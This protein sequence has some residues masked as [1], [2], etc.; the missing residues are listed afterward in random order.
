MKGSVRFLVLCT[1]V[2]VA[3]CQWVNQTQLGTLPLQRTDASFVY[4]A[5]QNNNSLCRNSPTIVK[6]LRWFDDLNNQRWAQKFLEGVEGQKFLVSKVEAKSDSWISCTPGESE[7]RGQTKIHLNRPFFVSVR[8]ADVEFLRQTMYLSGFPRAFWSWSVEDIQNTC[9]NNSADR[10]SRSRR[11][12]R[13]PKRLSVVLYKE[14]N[15]KRL[16]L[17]T[18]TRQLLTKLDERLLGGCPNCNGQWLV[19]SSNKSWP[20]SGA[21]KHTPLEIKWLKLGIKS[22]CC[23]AIC[24]GTC[25]LYQNILLALEPLLPWSDLL[26]NYHLPHLLPSP[27]LTPCCNTSCL[28]FANKDC[29]NKLRTFHKRL[30]TQP[31]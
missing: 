28:K 26:P 13:Q 24:R 8:P 1:I 9:W 4:S 17:K 27:K 21:V 29:I 20:W 12:G 10:V 23:F 31:K 11:Q 15:W 25:L 5:T 19:D 3:L 14:T 30:K 6:E 2:S 22:N 7:V 18:P 16:Q